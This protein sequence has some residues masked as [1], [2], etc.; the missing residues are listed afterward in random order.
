MSVEGTEQVHKRE[1][2]SLEHALTLVGPELRGK[3]IRYG[4]D[5]MV[6]C[7]VV[8]FGSTKADCHRVAKRIA[9]LVEFFELRLVMVWRRRNT[10]EITL[11]D[12]LSKDFDLS[13]YRLSQ[14]SFDA[15][16]E[17]FGPWE[18]DWFASDW[19]H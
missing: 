16:N 13:E 5:N 3:S 11:C 14:E 9:E 1:L 18:V 12:K 8:E 10:E 6:A 4:N 15:L 2:R 17:E 7:K 19:S